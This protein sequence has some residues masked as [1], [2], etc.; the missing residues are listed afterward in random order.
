[1]GEAS[2]HDPW[3]LVVFVG[4]NGVFC[5]LLWSAARLVDPGLFAA[6]SALGALALG[7]ADTKAFPQPIHHLTV[8]V[9]TTALIGSYAEVTGR[10]PGAHLVVLQKANRAGEY[11]KVQSVS[12]AAD[13]R[14]R[15]GFRLTRNEQWIRLISVDREGRPGAKSVRVITGGHDRVPPKIKLQLNTDRGGI[16]YTASDGSG[17]V[18]SVVTLR[19]GGWKARLGKQLH[20]TSNRPV[21]VALPSVHGKVRVCATAFDWSHNRNRLCRTL[22]LR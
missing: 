7:V 12:V 17:F 18:T 19:H 16:R 22:R 4:L 20:S 1:M 15:A 21:L 9:P 10:A 3:H 5:Y 2:L 11:H 6:I 14:Y 8:D 13:G